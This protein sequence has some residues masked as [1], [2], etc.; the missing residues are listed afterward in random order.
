M[1]HSFTIKHSSPPMP[2]IQIHRVHY[3]FIDIEREVKSKQSE[4]G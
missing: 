3:N 1:E 2:E 4:K